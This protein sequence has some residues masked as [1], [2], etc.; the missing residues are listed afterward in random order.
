MKKALL[1]LLDPTL[2]AKVRALLR[3]VLALVGMWGL[4]F[5]AEAPVAVVTAAQLVLSALVA[6]PTP[7]PTTVPKG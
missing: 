4:T 6:L 1:I 7:S 2:G 3:A 5:D